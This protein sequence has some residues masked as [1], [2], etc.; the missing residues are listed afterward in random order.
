MSL[1]HT[2]RYRYC[3]ITSAHIIVIMLTHIVT[4]H[5]SGDFITFTHRLRYCH[6][7]KGTLSHLI[8]AYRQIEHSSRSA[9]IVTS[10][11]TPDH[12]TSDQ[13]HRISTY[14]TQHEITSHHIGTYHIS[15]STRSPS[16]QIISHQH[17]CMHFHIKFG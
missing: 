15:H 11:T 6:I 5:T 17:I 7:S 14:L 8:S 10:H 16:D 12:V 4:S 13:S 9:H 1:H 3:H 2:Y